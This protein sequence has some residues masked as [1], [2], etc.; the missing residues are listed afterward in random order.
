MRFAWD[1]KKNQSNLLKHGFDF[2]KAIEIFNEPFIIKLDERVDYGEDRWIILG[3]IKEGIILV[4]FTIRNDEIR[5]ISARTASRK[6]RNI[7]Y[8]KIR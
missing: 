7:Y 5:L 4:A 3:K 6:E 8:D 1:E 2:N